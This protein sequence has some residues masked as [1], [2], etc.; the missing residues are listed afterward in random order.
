MTPDHD[1]TPRAP[2]PI[3]DPGTAGRRRVRR[4]PESGLLPILLIDA[5]AL[6]LVVATAPAAWRSSF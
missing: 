4:P 2:G 1:A 6:L 3:G 5:L